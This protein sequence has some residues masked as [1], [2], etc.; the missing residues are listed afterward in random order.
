MRAY[1][2]TILEC[3]R[4]LCD[5]R[6]GQGVFSVSDLAQSVTIETMLQALL[7]VRKPE[8]LKELIEVFW[9]WND[10]QS[11]FGNPNAANDL[12]QALSRLHQYE[13]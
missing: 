11:P 9:N 6:L 8:H 4:K 5:Q 3:I 1:A 12:F 13:D 2:D 7:G 10:A